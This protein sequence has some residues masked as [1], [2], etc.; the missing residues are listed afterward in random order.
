MRSSTS[1]SPRLFP[2]VLA[3]ATAFLD[4]YSTQPLLPFLARA[5]KATTLGVS[6][7]VTA[8][9]VGVAI[10]A[11]LVGR[12]ADRVGRKRVI[13]GAA[14]ALALAT[15]MASTSTTLGQL[16]AWRFL[17]G[18]FTPGVFAVTIAYI[19]EQ[20]PPWR[21]GAAT[22]AYVS[23]TVVGGFS[24]RVIAGVVAADITWR[25][26]FVVLAALNL[27]AAVALWRWLPVDLH[28]VHA[29]EESRVDAL[30]GHLR[31]PQLVSA[32]VVGSGVLFS[33]V[34]LFTYVTFLLAAPPFH[35]STVAL[36]S[37]FSVYLVGAVIT[38]FVGP[39]IDRYG[40]DRGMA[41]A[42]T[43]GVVGAL[44]TLVG[45]LATILAG[46]AIASTGVFIAQAAASSYVGSAATR[47]RGLAVGLYA[48]CYYLG[49]SAGGSLPALF[50]DRWGWPA[51]V[52][53]VVVVQ[54]IVG[55]IA[56]RFWH[57][58]N[59]PARPAGPLRLRV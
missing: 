54:L 52:I 57:P 51:C 41:V 44:L 32:F 31:N 53:L 49:G 9:T 28:P 3:G 7:T 33:L 56:L 23:G 26:S 48:T 34:A 43:F 47:N 46:L 19:H 11:P 13:V 21:A 30:V 4:L 15:L 20:W 29:R 18:V 35:L 55:A 25:S 16:I 42:I 12:L 58:H 5:F 40:H 37:V 27:G 2:V 6:L 17:Q 1:E 10:A 59:R 8:S 39:V 24:G 36:G 22:A 50:W 38:P 45:T 14:L